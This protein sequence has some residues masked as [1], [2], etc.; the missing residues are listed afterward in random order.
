MS[1]GLFSLLNYRKFLVLSLTFHC[2]KQ[3]LTVYDIQSFD[4][5]LGRALLEFQA[6]IERKRYLESISPGKSSMDLDFFHGTRIEDLCLD[7]SLPGYPDYVPESVSDSK[8][9]SLQECV[10]G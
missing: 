3:E 4:V 7:F 8:M 1:S 9:V 6:L 5:E 10:V 2:L